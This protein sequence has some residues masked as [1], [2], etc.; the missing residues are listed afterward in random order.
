LHRV[1]FHASAYGAWP[2]IAERG[3]RT[4]AQLL[5]ADERARSVPRTANV[6]V[7]DGSGHPATVRDQ[8]QMLRAAIEDH[9][10]GVDLREW[11]GIVNE[12]VY[13]YARQKDLTTLLTR[14][15]ESE[16][17]DVMVMDTA[18]LLAAAPGRVE[19]TEVTSAAPVPWTRCP[20][21][22]RGTFV[23]IERYQGNVADIEEVTVVG[24]LEQVGPLVTRVVRYHPDHTAEVLVA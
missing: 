4:A 16:G 9:L 5:V 24:G 11:L 18:R 15:Q 14:Y 19:V 22:G 8:R 6:E 13:F 1:V 10:D 20:C 7:D 3:L 12:R 23:P 21:R 2:S 17:Q